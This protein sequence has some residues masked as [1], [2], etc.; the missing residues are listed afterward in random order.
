[1]VRTGQVEGPAENIFGLVD[2]LSLEVL[3]VAVPPNPHA[4]DRPEGARK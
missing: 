3:R 1:M 2:Q 4:A